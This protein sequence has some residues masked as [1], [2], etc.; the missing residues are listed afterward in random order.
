M[1]RERAAWL[2]VAMLTG[3][4]AG[5]RSIAAPHPGDAA[6]PTGRLAGPP[7]ILRNRAADLMVAPPAAPPDGPGSP[8]PV[9]PHAHHRRTSP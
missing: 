1:G 7:A 5:P 8:T 4:A 9:D 2:V 3:C 6:A